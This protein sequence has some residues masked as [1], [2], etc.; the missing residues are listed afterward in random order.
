[1]SDNKEQNQQIDDFSQYIKQQLKGHRTPPDA[2]CWDEIGKRLSRR[3]NHLLLSRSLCIAGAA[4][5]ALLLLFNIP[6]AKDTPSNHSESIEKIAV[7][8]VKTDKPIDAPAATAIANVKPVLQS[9]IVATT[10]PEED[11]SGIPVEIVC[12]FPAET[13]TETE[14]QDKTEKDSPIVNR[15]K[16]QTELPVLPDK[17]PILPQKTTQ[18]RDW[19]IGAGLIAMNNTTL[20]NNE[21]SYSNDMSN[22]P[23]DG[24]GS[25]IP[26][27]P[28]YNLELRPDNCDD[29]DYHLPLSFGI[30]ARKQIT[31]KLSVET[32]LIYTYLHTTL[33]KDSPTPIKGKL[34]LHYLGIPVNLIVDLWDNSKWDIYASGGIMAE[35][36]LRSVYTQHFYRAHA[37]EESTVRTSISGMQ[38][39]ASG[40]LGVSYLLHKDWSIYAEPRISYFFDNNQPVSVRTDKPLSFGFGMG[41]RF[42]F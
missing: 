31:E 5:I 37:K 33:R 2:A 13:D 6:V 14:S 28:S 22:S 25:Y 8:E 11:A 12:K 40:A 42:N 16:K 26:S 7:H 18:K 30:T 27:P 4:A 29:I 19:Q 36:G 1:M 20:G 10:I 32:G 24:L 34:G 9:S 41:V 39:S 21:N 38:W 3:R 15:K 23:N 17:H 35:K